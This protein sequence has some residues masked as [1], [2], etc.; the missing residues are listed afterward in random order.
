MSLLILLFTFTLLLLLTLVW[1]RTLLLSAGASLLFAILMQAVF[2]GLEYAAL[3]RA[4]LHGALTAIE[5]GLLVFGALS[6]F[7]YLKAGDFLPK[8]Q[9]SV[10]QFSTNRLIVTILLVLFF[11]AFVEGISGFGTPAMIIAPLLLALGFSPALAAVL[12]L[13]ANTVPVLFGAVGTPV[14]IGFAELPVDKVPVYGTLL[15]VVP[16]MVLPFFFKRYLAQENSLRTTDSN[17]KT[18]LVLISAGIAFALPF[19][20]LS[21]AGPEFPSI[22]SGI[23][24]L[25]FWL[26]VVRMINPSGSV[27]NAKTLLQFF[28]TFKPYLL[29]ALL[30]LLAKLLL[31]NAKTVIAWPQIGLQK[32]I[33]AFQPGI[34]FLL[35]MM[36]LY[37]TSRQRTTVNLKRIFV[38]T[39][40]RLPAVLG[41]ITFL[42]ILARLLSQNL[43]VTEVFGEATSLPSGVF[44][45]GAVLTGVLGSFMAGSATVSNL[46]FGAQWYQIGTGYTLPVQLLLACQLAGAAIGNALSIQ[47]IVMVQAVLNEKGLER[48]VIGKLWKVI[49]L[50]FVLVSVAA[51]VIAMLA[52]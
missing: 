44:Y 10:R 15:M 52:R 4:V 12:P 18:A 43:D 39:L 17:R 8:L 45:A 20:L 50:F 26:F 7:N 16:V 37:L 38:Q 1:K 33:A 30:L 14:K 6:F 46:L 47:N 29:I 3:S 22:L 24:G 49:F 25:L 51:L 41:T 9:Q 40:A 23:I 28:Q 31:G 19:V 48:V 11:G 36:L 5:I 35:G 13:L 27:I 21:F 34:I 32:N 2:Y 42:A